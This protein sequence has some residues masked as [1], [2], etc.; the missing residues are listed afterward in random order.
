[1][2]LLL[3]YTSWQI[4]HR[5]HNLCHILRHL[6]LTFLSPAAVLAQRAQSGTAYATDLKR[7]KL[8]L[9]L[10]AIA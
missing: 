4:G 1:M 7:L 9:K 6:S 5:K 3:F 2:K 10:Y 8:L